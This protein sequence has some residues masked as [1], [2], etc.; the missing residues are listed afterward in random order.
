VA[1]A[2]VP[3][4]AGRRPPRDSLAVAL[5]DDLCGLAR[6]LGPGG[7]QARPGYAAQ[8]LRGVAAETGIAALA[9]RAAT[10]IRPAA[11]R[12]L[13]GTTDDLVRRG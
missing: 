8:F 12:R 6:R 5:S 3:Q 13:A 11:L 2:P 4:G 7:T 9:D 10:P 1:L